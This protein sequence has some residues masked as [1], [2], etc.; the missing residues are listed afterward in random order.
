MGGAAVSDLQTHINRVRHHR[1]PRQIQDPWR[2]EGVV[3][4]D[5]AESR[6]AARFDRGEYVKINGHRHD[7]DEVPDLADVVDL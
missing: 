5:A 3:Q 4:N 2:E 6:S 7:A 1:Q